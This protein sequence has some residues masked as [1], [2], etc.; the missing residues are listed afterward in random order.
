MS[1]LSY[2]SADQIA[3][4]ATWGNGAER[5]NALDEFARRLKAAEKWRTLNARKVEAYDAARAVVKREG[6]SRAEYV[7]RAE[8]AEASL[9]AAEDALDSRTL[10]LE[11]L[12]H[13][14]LKDNEYLVGVIETIRAA[15]RKPN[16]VITNEWYYGLHTAVMEALP[17]WEPAVL[18]GG[19]DTEKQP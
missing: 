1:A 11:A 9:K 8:T 19:S 10:E 2:L 17:D 15:A 6:F 4:K 14:R 13:V 16:G 5:L 7:L 12:K 18:R 3:E